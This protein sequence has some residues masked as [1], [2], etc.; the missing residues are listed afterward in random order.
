MRWRSS[1]AMVCLVAMSAISPTCIAS[2]SKFSDELARVERLRSS[3]TVAFNAG[4]SRLEANAA[5]LS[6]RESRWLRYL[7]DYRRV[8]QGEYGEAVGDAVALYDQAPETDIKFRAGLLIANAAAITRDFSLGLRYLEQSLALQPRISDAGVRNYGYTVAAILYNQYGQYELGLQNARA[9]AE[10]R[11]EPRSACFAQ[12]L[13]IEALHGLGRPIDET[14]DVQAAISRCTE[15]HE[16]IATN[17][18][19][20]ILAQRWAQEGKQRQA[21]ALL[22]ASLPEVEAT[23]YTRLIGEIHGLLAQLRLDVGDLA[24]AERDA[25]AVARIKGQDARWLPNVTAHH[26]LYELALKRGDYRTALDEYRQ[27]ADA[28]KARLDDVKAREY[29]F[30]LSRHELNQKNQSI[31]LLQSQNR[32]LQ[33]KQQAATASAWNTRLAIALLLVLVASVGYWGWRA[34]RMHGSL[35]TLAETDGLTG[36]ANRR[37]F[38]AS[39]EAVLTQCAQRQRPVAVLLFD[40]DHFKQINDQCGHASGDWVL[41]EVARVGRL[42][43]RETDLFGRIGGEEF[44]MALMDCEVHEAVGIAEACRRAIASIDAE[45]AGCCLPV[46]ASVGVVGTRQV[47]YDY[48]SL[49]AHA[50]AAM[51]RSKVGGR[52]R[53]TLYEPPALPEAGQPVL[54][55][56][57][58][59]EAMLRQY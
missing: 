49:I 17:L 9:L 48:E 53:V 42:H 50:D 25:R 4:L 38:R 16:P 6:P 33:L 56:Q 13:Q 46:S 28:D 10:A 15:A 24:A 36:L 21:I 7:Q 22:D 32:L 45:A 26:V 47:G 54:L 12:Q 40:L 52:N 59:A 19:R 29:A 2:V 51:Y 11:P 30:Q 41:R 1:L 3:D 23:G 18:I 5:K 8:I 27:Y 43:C 31:L 14:A 34:R 44:A 58:N 57:R 37:H 35:R 20:S 55:D 39:S